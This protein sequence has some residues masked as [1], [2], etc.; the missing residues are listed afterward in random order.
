[1]YTLALNFVLAL[2]GTHKNRFKVHVA[3]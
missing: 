1:M 3:F 2:A